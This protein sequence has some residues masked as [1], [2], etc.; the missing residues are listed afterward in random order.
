MR[1][2]L[3]DFDLPES[4]IALRP[5]VPRD[6]AALL[7]ISSTGALK[8]KKI[9]DLTS[10][11]RSGDVLIVNDTKVL[12]TRLE[13]IRYRKGTEGAK[14]EV[15]LIKSLDARR[16]QGLLK[17]AKRVKV[18]ETLT[19]DGTEAV[20]ESLIEGEVI[21]NF[22][23]PK[24]VAVESILHK[25]GMIPLPP[26]ISSRREADE[27]DKEDY[28]TLFAKYEGAVAAPTAG[29]HFTSELKENLRAK[30]INIHTVTLHVGAGTFLPVKVENTENH[31]MHHEWG[32]ISEETAV[33]LNQVK[34]A[35][36][37]LICVGTTSLRLIETAAMDDG[38][39]QA[40]SG[41][42]NIFI[43]PGYQFKAVDL[44]LTNFHL[45]KS[46]LFMLVSAFSGLEVMQNAYRHAINHG[47]RFYSY[48]DACLL[49]RAEIEG[50]I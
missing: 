28:Q 19:F 9:K 25:I 7:S 5:M 26:Y 12:P 15:T 2:D 36:G 38:Y 49:E 17:P 10:F 50:N 1:L 30:G 35:G 43:T 34:Q 3:F 48:G 27:R 46:T 22:S 45:P 39:L 41:E 23:L 32:S 33:A 4:R 8:N 18:G 13:A 11:L 47:Y 24:G 42:T 20:I 16:W 31:I 44:L 6:E 29:L 14:I 37:R 40:F 21:L